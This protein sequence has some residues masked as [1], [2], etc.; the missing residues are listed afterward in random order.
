MLVA[1]ELLFQIGTRKLYSGKNQNQDF[2]NIFQGNIILTIA[3][4]VEGTL[5]HL[6]FFHYLNSNTVY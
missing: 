1:I 5:D 4:R 6:D 3:F 2:V